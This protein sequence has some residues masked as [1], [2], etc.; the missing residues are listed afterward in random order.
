[1]LFVDR[2][3]A[4]RRLARRLATMTFERPVILGLP[5]GGVPVA[6]EVSKVISAPLDVVLVRKLGAPTNPEFAIGAI[7]EDGARVIDARTVAALGLSQQR[8][9]A[10]EEVERAEL[11]RRAVQFRGDRPPVPIDGATAILVDDGIATGATM[12]VACT[13]VRQR[14][15]SRIVVA[16]PVAPDDLDERFDADDYIALEK[17][18][19]FMAVGQWYSNFRQTTDDEVVRCLEAARSE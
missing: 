17:P 6:F 3:D 16:V 2:T 7:G 12:R 10:I 14:G 13:V 1:M 18:R 15:A 8:I 9:D 11:E 4:G 5:R 19:H